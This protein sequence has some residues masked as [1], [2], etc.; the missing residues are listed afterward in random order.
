[1]GSFNVS[2][3]AFSRRKYKTISKSAQSR[4]LILDAA[5]RIFGRKGYSASSLREIAE[6]VGMQA[7][8]LY[9]H[10]SSKDEIFDEVLSSGMRNIHERV[11]QA[12]SALGDGVTHRQRIECAMTAHLELL[13]MKREYYAPASRI[14]VHAPEPL[15]SHHR[16]LRHDYGKLWDGFLLDAQK[17]GEIRKEVKIVPLRML[18]LGALNWTLEWYDVDRYPIEGFV[19]QISTTVFEGVK[20]EAAPAVRAGHRSGR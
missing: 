19:R 15:A 18:I 3:Q 20:P 7:G 9:Y 5:A 2:G 11:E 14:L 8:S 4:L 12:V 1:M 17:A 16:E 6:A 13:L 10:F